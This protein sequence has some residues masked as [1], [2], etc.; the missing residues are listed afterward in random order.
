MQAAKA[1]LERLNR[2]GYAAYYVGGCVRDRLLQREISDVDITTAAAPQEIMALFP[3]TAPTGLRHGTV[4]VLLAD[5]AFEVTTFRTDGAYSDGRHPDAV[6][7]SASLEEDLRRR[8]F[9]INAMAMQPDGTVI[10]LFDGQGDLQRRLIRAV[11][12]PTERF[13]EDALRMLRAYRFAAQLGFA[14][15]PETRAAIV[16]CADGV[17]H[18]SAE[19]VRD[20]VQKLLCAPNPKLLSDVIAAGLL[21]AFGAEAAG[22][23]SLLSAVVAEPV[24]RWAA[25][26]V[27]VPQLRLERFRL[28]RKTERTAARAAVCYPAPFSRLSVKRLLAYEGEPVA[29]CVCAL[30]G[31]PALAEE[32]LRSGECV[33]LRTLALSGAALSFLHGRE[34]GEMQKYLLEQ[35]LLAPE[36]NERETLLAMARER[37]AAQAKT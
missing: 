6:R 21:R 3:H 1:V 17:Q 4:T 20:E 28:D 9:T 23:L 7:F 22:D 37:W 33:S 25:L 32:I 11:G 29:R 12:C 27:C 2:A 10:D 34:I 13:R 24:V 36:K 26:K 15:E 35:V 8:D 14:V 30:H 5:C 31:E 19:R 18:L 16:A